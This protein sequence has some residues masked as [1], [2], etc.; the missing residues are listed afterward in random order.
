[1]QKFSFMFDVFGGLIVRHEIFLIDTRQIRIV[2]FVRH[3]LFILDLLFLVC[4][5]G[6]ISF[7][8]TCVANL[9]FLLLLLFLHFCYLQSI[10]IR[11]GGYLDCFLALC[12]CCIQLFLIRNWL[13]LHFWVL[14]NFFFL[15]LLFLFIFYFLLAHFIK[16]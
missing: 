7:C 16:Y 12:F 9:F 11:I 1:M 8:L 14:L 5:A 15:L 6:L 3:L 2:E 10:G 4:F 13:V